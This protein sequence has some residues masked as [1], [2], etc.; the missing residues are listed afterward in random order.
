V[1]D[2]DEIN[3]RFQEALQGIGV[4]D[5]E[6][7]ITAVMIQVESN[8]QPMIPRATSTLANSVYR[9]VRRTATGWQ[10]DLGFGAS[11]AQHVHDA[12]GTLLG[13]NTPRRPRRLGVVWG[14]SGEPKFFKK[15]IEKTIPQL[16]TILR[17]EYSE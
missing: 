5:T 7:A 2:F 8:T 9:Y 15:G 6:R 12:P 13:T 4:R 17:E 11:Y 10:G 16:R 1:A 14:P 3:R